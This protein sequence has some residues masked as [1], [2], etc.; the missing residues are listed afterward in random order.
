MSGIEVRRTIPADL[1]ALAEVL[2]KV[3]AVDGYPVEGVQDPRAWVDLVDPIGQW[4]A[5]RDGRP[6]GHIALTAPQDLDAAP[7][8]IALQQ[9]VPVVEVAVVA[10]L[11]VDPEHRGQGVAD[12]LLEA[13]EREAQ[14]GSLIPVLDVVKKDATAISLYEK[15]GWQRLGVA[16]HA[17]GDGLPVPTIAMALNSPM[18]APLTVD[19]TPS[20]MSSVVDDDASRLKVIEQAYEKVPSIG[21]RWRWYDIPYRA[22]WWALKML[23][24]RAPLK[25]RMRLRQILN[26]FIAFNEFERLQ[27]A[28]EGYRARF[29]RSHAAPASEELEQVAIWAIEVFP[30]SYAQ[31]LFT[32]LEGPRWSEWRLRSEPW[33]TARDARVSNAFA[34]WRVGDVVAPDQQMYIPGSVIDHL[35]REFSEVEVTAQQL[36]SSMT[37]VVARFIL[38]EEVSRELESVW[39]SHHPPAL[40]FRGLNR[41]KVEYG[42][43]AE[44]TA[45]ANKRK[46]AHDAARKWLQRN[47]RGYFAEVGDNPVSELLL[48]KEFDPLEGNFEQTSYDPLEALGVPWSSWRYTSPQTVGLAHFPGESRLVRQEKFQNVWTI[49]G[50]KRVVLDENRES[51]RGYGSEATPRGVVHHINDAVLEVLVMV[52]FDEYQKR[53]SNRLRSLRDRAGS[54]HSKFRVRPVERLRRDILRTSLDIP[55]VR[56]DALEYWK[57]LEGR[58]SMQLVAHSID[59]EDRAE[60]R[61]MVPL[62]RERA[63]QQWDEIARNDATYR[64]VLA[65]AASLGAAARSTVLSRWAIFI[66]VSSL[67]VAAVTL[68]VN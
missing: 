15:R 50:R 47:F 46:T 41:P 8:M 57:V 65:T 52:A 14:E 67:A 60:T 1:D 4:T 58:P 16:S 63:I 10:R 59:P 66:A 45:I 62:F 34:W 49:A 42:P 26:F 44:R 18:A 13:A 61:E 43:F 64:D 27:K 29:D 19:L 31:N 36:G 3:H 40:R 23:G 9:S 55:W 17:D 11:F 21:E 5:L 22:A 33:V 53:L 25:L 24:K 6:V 37:A 35:P 56:Q 51:I 54:D 30:P 48:F 68:F 28:P 38:R 2:L 39:K 20:S 12:Q 7:Q 32:A